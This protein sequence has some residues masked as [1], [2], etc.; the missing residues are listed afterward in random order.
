[1]LLAC[2]PRKTN[3]G[4]AN[5][6]ADEAKS[7]LEAEAKQEKKN[8]KRAASEAFKAMEM[9]SPPSSPSKKG[10]GSGRQQRCESTLS[11]TVGQK[12]TYEG[13]KGTSL[14]HAIT[15]IGSDIGNLNADPPVTAGLLRAC[16][17]LCCAVCLLAA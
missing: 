16:T 4:K 8:A 17:V 10:T 14:L 12:G 6:S 3:G 7:R 1:M 5:E 2:R 15:V 9:S 13:V 11:R